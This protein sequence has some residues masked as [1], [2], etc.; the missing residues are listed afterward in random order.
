MK[1]KELMG[2]LRKVLLVLIVLWMITVFMLS[3]QSGEGSGSLSLAVTKWIFHNDAVAERMEPFIRKC[4]HMAEYAFGAML[5]YSYCLT[6]EKMNPR[7]QV[8]FAICATVLYAITDEIHQLFVNDR[9][10]QILD[11]LIDSAGAGLG[12]LIEWFAF[13]LAKGTE[14]EYRHPEERTVEKVI[15]NAGKK[16]PL[17]SVTV[18]V[19]DLKNKFEKGEEKDD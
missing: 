7:K 13:R 2:K 16:R 3:N 12:V 19:K 10:G 1:K 11:V 4:A 18:S 15:E 14:Y 8:L 5:F 6:Y 9:A 17:S